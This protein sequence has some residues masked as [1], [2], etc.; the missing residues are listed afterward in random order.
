MDK[1]SEVRAAK[2]ATRF[3]QHDVD[4]DGFIDQNDYRQLARRLGEG[5]G[6]SAVLQEEIAAGFAEQWTQ[7][8][9]LADVDHNGQVSLAEYTHAMGAGISADSAALER[10][11]LAT[12]RAA[13]RAADSDGDGYLDLAD[14]LRLAELL[15][16]PGAQEGF[17]ALD[18]DGAGRLRTEVVLA[19]VHDF[20]VSDDP[21]NPANLV[22][23]RP[24]STP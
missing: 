20:Y 2:L 5:L 23:G 11:V 22:F 3:A 21:D 12:S 6:A 15:K 14:Y 4:G 19:A 8:A 1:I 10:A 18:T 9:A 13:L 16:V 24:E 17:H 7:L